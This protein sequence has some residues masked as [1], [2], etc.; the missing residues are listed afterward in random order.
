MTPPRVP[1]IPI[2]AGNRAPRMD[3]SP[4]YTPSI[5]SY[6]PRSDSISSYGYSQTEMQKERQDEAKAINRE[7]KDLLRYKEDD[8]I[9][10]EEV[11]REFKQH[12]YSDQYQQEEY[13]QEETPNLDYEK[14]QQQPRSGQ[15]KTH[16]SNTTRAETF[17]AQ[18]NIKK[19]QGNPNPFT[20]ASASSSTFQYNSMKDQTGLQKV[21]ESN[22]QSDQH[23][24]ISKKLR[25]LIQVTNEEGETAII[26]PTR[27]PTNEKSWNSL[28][29]GSK[30]DH[31][32]EDPEDLPSIDHR[33]LQLMEKIRR[34]EE[35]PMIALYDFKGEMSKDLSFKKGDLVRL[36]DRKQNGWWLAEVDGRI[37]F[38]PSN[39][40][41]CKDDLG[42]Q[43]PPKV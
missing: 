2:K 21:V 27:K 17:G 16:D 29:G 28:Q 8:M 13:M 25:E 31:F 5:S 14:N 7:F 40:L 11:E 38:V 15:T 34:K 22:K 3:N 18:A 30:P 9:S 32:S 4:D 20:F 23:G 36:I 33:S 41:E 42:V 35:V 12:P 6:L 24:V 39:F 37:G 19:E 10:I 1:V 43:K 26:P